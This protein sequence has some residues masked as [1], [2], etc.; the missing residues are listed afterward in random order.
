MAH[1]AY[2]FDVNTVLRSSA[3]PKKED[4]LNTVFNGISS[5]DIISDLNS[6]VQSSSS[7]NDWFKVPISNNILNPIISNDHNATDINNILSSKDISLASDLNNLTLD[8]DHSHQQKLSLFSRLTSDISSN[9]DNQTN[10]GSTV[11]TRVSS[12]SLLQNPLLSS[13]SS[14]AIA[15]ATLASVSSTE[16]L[17]STTAGSTNISSNSSTVTPNHIS[18]SHGILPTSL[19]T[20]LIPPDQINW[21]YLDSQNQVQGPFAGTIM[22]SWY[23]QGYFSYDLKIKRSTE[24]FFYNLSSFMNSVQNNITPFLIALPATTLQFTSPQEQQ[25]PFIGSNMFDRTSGF[26]ITV[27]NSNLN[28]S[29]STNPQD[30]L[31]SSG[32]DASATVAVTAVESSSSSEKGYASKTTSESNNFLSSND[33][34]IDFTDVQQVDATASSH[35]T[36]FKEIQKHSNEIITQTKTSDGVA[37]NQRN[38]IEQRR[39]SEQNSNEKSMK[40]QNGDVF[41]VEQKKHQEQVSKKNVDAKILSS[42]KAQELSKKNSPDKALSLN[43]HANSKANGVADKGL[44]PV[45]EKDAT[46]SANPVIEKLVPAVSTKSN[47]A[48]WAAKAS[49]NHSDD[50]S[51]SKPN[52]SEPKVSLQEILKM[53]AEEKHRKQKEKEIQSAKLLSQIM[54][55]EQQR[56]KFTQTNKRIVANGWGSNHGAQPVETMQDILKEEKKASINKKSAV[57]ISSVLEPANT[58]DFDD[59]SSLLSDSGE[60]WKVVNKKTTPASTKIQYKISTGST[61]GASASTL[62]FASIAASSTKL[63]SSTS[64]GSVSPLSTNNL[65]KTVPSNSYS[66]IASSGS[67]SSNK[68]RRE[69][70][71]WCR[72]EL[73]GLNGGVNKEDILSMFFQFHNGKESKDLISDTIYSSS[74]TMNGRRFAEEFIKRRKMVEKASPLTINWDDALKMNPD[75]EDEDEWTTTVNKKKGKK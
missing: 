3:L 42:Q 72:S 62:N 32:N 45:N 43:R 60:A 16:Q 29:T 17:A 37:S 26:D 19:Y 25:Q 36:G 24:S 27:N 63:V 65:K 71:A 20:P 58:K 1:D 48:P 38:G 70:L 10:N 59:G 21:L 14:P 44:P 46:P 75:D 54:K 2:S 8:I 23:S 50:N 6:T 64:S 40:N 39:I 7:N 11:P 34:K 67:V 69:F 52:N 4:P 73:R 55:E 51:S 41:S 18:H 66:S 13:A 61:T 15:A 53:E 68:V 35:S 49:L 12:V 57:P 74:K 9:S 30:Q 47:L 56:K 5:S 28:L 31:I 33:G 22:Q